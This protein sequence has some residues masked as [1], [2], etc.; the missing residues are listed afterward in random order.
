MSNDISFQNVMN[1]MLG[2][3]SDEFDKR[4][5]SVIYQATAMVVPELLLIQSE[6]EIMENEAFP[7]TCGYNNLVRFASLRGI[8]PKK[9]TF[10]TVKAVFNI[11][12]NLGTRFNFDKRNYIVSEKIQDVSDG[13][14]EYKLIAEEVGHIES[15]GDITPIEDIPGLTKATITDVLVDGTEDESIESLR[16]MYLLSIENLSFGGNRADY[17]DKVL[18]IDNVGA[19]KVIRRER[20]TSSEL[21]KIEVLVLDNTFKDSPSDLIKTVQDTLAPLNNTSGVGLAPIGHNVLVSGVG[22]ETINIRTRL[23]LSSGSGDVLEDVKTKIEEYLQELRYSFGDSTPIVVRV[24]RIENRLFDIPGVIDVSNTT[25]NG[26]ERNVTI[27][28]RIIPVLGSV[29]YDRG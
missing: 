16:N 14:K 15:I 12:V 13:N 22:K 1:R 20:A 29:N 9:A 2:N 24:S 17:I 5:T 11:D 28:D 6:L 27:D 3:I 25:I 10:G 8:E 26:A 4:E 19:C 23:T 21:G 7:D 18:S